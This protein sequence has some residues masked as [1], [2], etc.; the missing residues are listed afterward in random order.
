MEKSQHLPT[1]ETGQRI[2]VTMDLA[3]LQSIFPGLDITV[4]QSVLEDVDSHF[5]SAAQTLLALQNCIESQET[6]SDICFD[7]YSLTY[8]VCNASPL[9]A[10]RTC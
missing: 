9:Y 2:G 8:P 4:I 7:R 10:G 6:H 1:S 3:L 5:Q